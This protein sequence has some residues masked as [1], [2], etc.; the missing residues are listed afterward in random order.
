MRRCGRVRA[1]GTGAR[2]LGKSARVIWALSLAAGIGNAAPSD[3][4]PL[5]SSSARAADEGVVR[6]PERPP[7][8][9]LP[10]PPSLE[11]PMP[12]PVVLEALDAHLA[13][14]V[15]SDATVRE[16]AR[17][18]ILE[19]ELDRLPS[20]HRRLVTLS[21]SS[22]H[23]GMK[24]L[25]SGIRDKARDLARQK[26]RVQGVN[27]KVVTPDYLEMLTQH[28]K[29][30]SKNWRDLVAVVAMSRMLR[31]IGTVAAGRELV[32][33]Y[34]RFGEFLRVDV[35][36]QFENMGDHAIAPL[37]EAERHPAPK[38][39]HWA[40]RQLDAIGKAIPGEAVQVSDPEV[41]ADILRAYGLARDPDA[42][43]L[44]ISFANSERTQI[45]E[46]ARQ[47]VA[48]LGEVG[49][50][51]LRDTYENVVGKKP[52]RE[53]SWDRTA[54]E[55]FAEFD[56][57]RLAHVYV[58]FEQGLADQKAGKLDDMIRSFDEVLARSP[59]FEH[60]AEMVPGYVA[61]AHAHLDDS[62]DLATRALR[63]I[64]RLAP[65]GDPDEKLAKSLLL[66]LEAEEL[67]GKNIAD[68][69]LAERALELDP[70]NARARSL[71]K[72]MSQTDGEGESRFHRYIA[73]GA[74][75]A[76]AIGAVLVLLLRK[77]PGPEPA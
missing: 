58:L 13:R 3:V 55:L 31:Q 42:A 39:A 35:Q 30:D 53:W 74:I 67:F 56:R 18:E 32:G 59:V 69:I 49:N 6:A 36:L 77:K 45:R 11:L 43:R 40:A 64:E 26:L 24:D 8:S 52:P 68:P 21:E 9:P 10:K 66:T 47:A 23:E 22:D 51:Q 75:A 15:S 25:L 14:L 71:L 7:L 12:E 60:G 62:R 4:V 27:E 50:W 41:L 1:P 76:A 16:T 17:E 37:I 28:A 73:A 61:Y 70:T 48:L 34:A 54:R 19:V 2:R 65:D 63:R 44:V 46:A 38:I 20:I 33:V 72:K 5:P 57:T 29:P